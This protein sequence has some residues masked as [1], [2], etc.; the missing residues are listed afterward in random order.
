VSI[1]IEGVERTNTV[2]VNLQAE[3]VLRHDTYVIDVNWGW[4][5]YNYR[6]FGHIAKYCR[7]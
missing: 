5:Y 2:I 4:N 1:L 3:F 7:N 6:E